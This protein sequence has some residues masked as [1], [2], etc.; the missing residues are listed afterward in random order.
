MKWEAQTWRK[1]MNVKKLCR[2][3]NNSNNIEDCAGV[4][5]SRIQC[6][7]MSS[8]S[9]SV[10]GSVEWCP[11]LALGSLFNTTGDPLSVSV[12]FTLVWAPLFC[13]SSF[14]S[15]LG[16]VVVHLMTREDCQYLL[17]LPQ[18]GPLVFL[19]RWEFW[20]T[21]RR[22]CSVFRE[23][24]GSVSPSPYNTSWSVPDSVQ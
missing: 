8:L 9:V 11:T 10:P 7:P 22:H 18:R 3:E 16:P 17:H 24:G 2:R 4:Y 19:E 20:V 12:S 23:D 21:P 14:P 1:K 15:T 5:L 6:S 13:P